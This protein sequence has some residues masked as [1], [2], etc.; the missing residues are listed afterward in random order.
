LS[1]L[2]DALKVNIQ[3]LVGLVSNDSSSSQH[4][5][6]NGLSVCTYFS[7]STSDGQTAGSNL[8][9]QSSSVNRSAV[10]DSAKSAALRA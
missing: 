5:I 7:L 10:A 9:A 1:I 6:Y 4:A 3:S 2:A 8:V